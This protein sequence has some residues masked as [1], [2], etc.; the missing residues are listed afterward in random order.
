MGH[1]LDSLKAIVI[2]TLFVVFL[3]HSPLLGNDLSLNLFPLFK[4]VDSSDCAVIETSLDNV[5]STR[6]FNFIYQGLSDPEANEQRAYFRPVLQSKQQQMSILAPSSPT[7]PTRKKNNTFLITSLSSAAILQAADYFTSLNALKYSSLEE[8]NPLL[9]NVAGDP[10]LFG[11]VKLCATGLQV[12]ILKKLHDGNKTL[13]WIVG[14]A[15]NV[16]LSF[17]VANNL[18]QIQKARNL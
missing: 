18:H 5:N 7:F 16:A 14:T 6:T 10:L 13:A 17:V 11:V 2:G 9:K 12:V 3:S 8:G 15:M 4:T 1:G